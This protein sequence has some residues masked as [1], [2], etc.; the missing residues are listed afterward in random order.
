MVVGLQMSTPR[1]NLKAFAVR[2]PRTWALRRTRLEVAVARLTLRVQDHRQD[3]S[4]T[5]PVAPTRSSSV[6][7]QTKLGRRAPMALCRLT[8]LRDILFIKSS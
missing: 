6:V 5:R 1:P 2:R 3:L 8:T 7:R 4:G